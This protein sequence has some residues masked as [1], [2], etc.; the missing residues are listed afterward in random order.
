LQLREASR[1]E[2]FRFAKEIFLKESPRLKARVTRYDILF[3]A[4]KPDRKAVARSSF[5]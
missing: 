2:K 3:A 5:Y 1:R 4:T